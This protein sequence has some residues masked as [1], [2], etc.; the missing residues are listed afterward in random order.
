METDFSISLTDSHICSI[1]CLPCYEMEIT[2]LYIHLSPSSQFITFFLEHAHFLCRLHVFALP[3]S[4]F[5]SSWKHVFTFYTLWLL[6]TAHWNRHTWSQCLHNWDHIQ[7]PQDKN[8]FTKPFFAFQNM[9][10]FL[11][12]MICLSKN[13]RGVWEIWS[14]NLF[15]SLIEIWRDN[16]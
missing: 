12:N 6:F 4:Y 11:Y 1:N 10:L 13:A 9:L 15:K 5:S 7:K 14:E 2:A 8:R 16:V 3:S